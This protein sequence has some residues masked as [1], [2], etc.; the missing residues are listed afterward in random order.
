MDNN[1]VI[2]FILNE[3]LITIA[4]IGSVVTFQFLST[5]KINI[6]DPLIDFALPSDK[7]DFMN[8][9][10]KDGESTKPQNPKLSMDFGTFFR[11]FVKF[12]VEIFLLYLISKNT[13]FP[14]TMGGNYSG[15]A[16]M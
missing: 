15:A 10:L 4:V 6:I 7:F 2:K 1:N 13:K 9:T 11:E 5:F 14:Q 12:L 3:K 16:I 8:L